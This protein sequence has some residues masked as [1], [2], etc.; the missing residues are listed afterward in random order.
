MPL[1]N[2]N[3]NGRFKLAILIQNFNYAF[4]QKGVTGRP[5]TSPCLPN[6][7]LLSFREIIRGEGQDAL[8]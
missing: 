8:P 4:Y 2:G 5:K 6:D 1:G 3:G 7:F